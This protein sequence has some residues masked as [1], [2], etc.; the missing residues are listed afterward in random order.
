MDVKGTKLSFVDEDLVRPPTSLVT[1][2]CLKYSLQT[3]LLQELSSLPRLHTLVDCVV[4]YPHSFN[5]QRR[6]RFA[7]QSYWPQPPL[8]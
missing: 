3:A 6:R 1:F 7:K 4:D 2:K 8:R 5:L